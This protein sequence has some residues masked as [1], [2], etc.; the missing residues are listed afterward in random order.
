M[1][2]RFFDAD[3][4][5]GVIETFQKHEGKNIIRRHQN[6]DAIFNANNNELNT[7]S[8]GNNWAGDMHKVASIP[9][10]VVDMW[11]EELKAKG[12]HNCNPLH[13]DNKT[14]LIAK[15]NSSEWSKL[16]TKQG[17]I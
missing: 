6:T 14:F 15:I 2:E 7:H 5:T 12:L 10:I 4:Y 1:S 9:L 16:R 8:S 11:R 13:N 3:K 17:R